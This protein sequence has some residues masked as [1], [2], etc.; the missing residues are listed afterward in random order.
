MK[1]HNGMDRETALREVMLGAPTQP[2]FHDDRAGRGNR[3]VPMHRIGSPDYRNDDQ[4]RRRL[5]GA[6]GPGASHLAESVTYL[7]RVGIC[8]GKI[9][10][11]Q[12]GLESG[13]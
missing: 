10:G 3:R 6:L 11:V 4:F 12:A 7:P 2:Y 5:D 1:A 13:L 8:G 9:T